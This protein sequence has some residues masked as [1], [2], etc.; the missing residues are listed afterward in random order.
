MGFQRSIKPITYKFWACVRI[1][2]ANTGC[3]AVEKVGSILKTAMTQKQEKKV[4]NTAIKSDHFSLTQII[5]I[6]S[7]VAQ[8][9]KNSRC[10]HPHFLNSLCPKNRGKTGFLLLSLVC[11]E[12]VVFFTAIPFLP[13][14][15]ATT[16]RAGIGLHTSNCNLNILNLPS[17]LR[18][19][20]PYDN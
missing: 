15:L 18:D 6:P 8:V 12:M 14:I 10:S 13:E 7:E 5:F 19:R 16:R 3:F 17:C 2:H 20:S 1:L 4:R 9:M 11:G